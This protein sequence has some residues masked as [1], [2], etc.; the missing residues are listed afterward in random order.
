MVRGAKKALSQPVICLNDGMKYSSMVEASSQRYGTPR[1][2]GYISDVCKGKMLHYRNDVFRF[3]S[4][5][6]KMSK[7]ELAQISKDIE[8]RNAPKIEKKSKTIIRYLGVNYDCLEEVGY[9]LKADGFER[10]DNY[11]HNISAMIG[12]AKNNNCPF[13]RIKNSSDEGHYYLFYSEYLYIYENSNLVDTRPVNEKIE[14]VEEYY[15]QQL[16]RII[17]DITISDLLYSSKLTFY[18]FNNEYYKSKKSIFEKYEIEREL[19]RMETIKMID[20]GYKPSW[21]YSLDEMLK[22]NKKTF[23]LFDDNI[24]WSKSEHIDNKCIKLSK[25]DVMKELNL[26]R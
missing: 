17:G 25:E 15:L 5:Y 18:K 10:A 21:N 8:F 13:V 19:T 22:S 4:I 2:N 7:D 14:V 20:K 12:Q 6:E 9:R 3:I 16:N 23:Y 26:R 1:K 24:Y 11:G